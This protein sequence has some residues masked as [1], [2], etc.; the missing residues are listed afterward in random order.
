MV[1]GEGGINYLM[2]PYVCMYVCYNIYLLSNNMHVILVS[3][4]FDLCIHCR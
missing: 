2:I 4:L 3:T 1:T